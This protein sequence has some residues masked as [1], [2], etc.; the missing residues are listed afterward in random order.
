MKKYLLCPFGDYDLN[1]KIFESPYGILRDLF[2]KKEISLDTYDLGDIKTA[3]TIL[4]FNHN[5]KLLQKCE[6]SGVTKDKLILFLFE[7][8]VVLPKQYSNKTKS[9]YGKIFILP[10]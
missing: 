3:D 2:A 7:P 10:R 8:E 1:N 9:R 6:A 4:F 5:E